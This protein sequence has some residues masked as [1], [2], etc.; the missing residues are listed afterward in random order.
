[1]AHER[2][3]WCGG[4]V[5]GA[6]GWRRQRV[7]IGLITMERGPAEV[8]WPPLPILLVNHL[9]R[10]A[11]LVR[12]G[13]YRGSHGLAAFPDR[14]KRSGRLVEEDK[15]DSPGGE[16]SLGELLPPGRAL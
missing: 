8:L 13:E 14:G 16:P 15:G 2:R 3:S 10:E 9:P 5:A 1:M 4:Q 11:V 7:T 6:R 12:I